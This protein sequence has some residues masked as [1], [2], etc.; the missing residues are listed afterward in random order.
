MIALRL[1]RSLAAALVVSLVSGPAVAAD[2]ISVGAEGVVPV[3]PGNTRSMRERALAAAIVAA[4]LEASRRYLAPAVFEV[5]EERGMKSPRMLP[6][7]LIETTRYDRFTRNSSMK[8]GRA[9]PCQR[10]GRRFE[11]GLVLQK[12]SPRQVVTS[13]GCFASEVNRPGFAGGSIP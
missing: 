7:L 1:R 13:A 6:P 3:S 9:S 4:V 12:T 8:S 5:E 10:G 11:P 2:P